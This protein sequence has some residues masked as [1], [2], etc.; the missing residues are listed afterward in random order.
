MSFLDSQAGSSRP[1][2]LLLSGVVL[3][4]SLALGACDGTDNQLAPST[5]DP[6]APGSDA[7]ASASM[8]ADDAL[9]VSTAQRIV[10]VSWRQGNAEI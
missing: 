1:L 4:G 2:C 9:L 7:A 3:A 10:F 6:M 8:A 5:E